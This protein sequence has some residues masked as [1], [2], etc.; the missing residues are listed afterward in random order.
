MDE[1]LKRKK[2]ERK[3]CFISTHNVWTGTATTRLWKVFKLIKHCQ[4]WNRWLPFNDLLLLLL[5]SAAATTT[6]HYK[7]DSHLERH[8]G[9]ARAQ[10]APK[11]ITS[12]ET[13]LSLSLSPPPSSWWLFM[14]IPQRFQRHSSPL[15]IYIYICIQVGRSAL[16]CACKFKQHSRS[17]N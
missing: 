1:S 2:Q 13:P 11:Q 7:V 5:Y 17:G 9:G 10:L 8:W 14:K 3:K 6:A 4:S 16:L 15:Y 12:F